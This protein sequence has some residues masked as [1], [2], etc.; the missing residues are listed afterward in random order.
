MYFIFY[1]DYYCIYIF[2]ELEIKE[3]VFLSIFHIG[4]TSN[5]FLKYKRIRSIFI[6]IYNWKYIH[7][8]S[9]F[10]K[11]LRTSNLFIKSNQFL[12]ISLQIPKKN[13]FHFTPKIYYISS[14]SLSFFKT[15][16]NPG[17]LST[18]CAVVL[19]AHNT[20][21]TSDLFQITTF[22]FSINYLNASG[23]PSISKL[24]NEL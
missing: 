1:F 23:I 22:P 4:K 9:Y 24:G 12:K 20:V 8:I 16:S 11:I 14:T 6:I 13:Y 10:Q 18:N 19:S 3:K 7:K 21:I 17:F 15:K 2:Q 5:Q